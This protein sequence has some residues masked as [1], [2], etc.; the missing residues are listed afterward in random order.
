MGPIGRLNKIILLLL[1]LGAPLA[2]LP[3]NAPWGFERSVLLIA[4]FLALVVWQLAAAVGKANGNRSYRTY[5]TD[6]LL[7]AALPV[8]AFLSAPSPDVRWV[9][10]SSLEL[11][12]A[13]GGILAAVV[14]PAANGR[15]GGARLPALALGALVAVIG[16]IRPI[17]PIGPIKQ[18]LDYQASLGITRST[19]QK[20]PLWGVGP[21]KFGE[22]FLRYKTTD[23][24]SREDWIL[25]YNGSQSGLLELATE[26]GLIGLIGP[27]GLIGL[28]LA[29]LNKKR[30]VG[31][32][33]TFYL[34]SGLL[35]VVVASFVLLPYSPGV[36]WVLGI[37]NGEA[38]KLE[39]KAQN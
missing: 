22:S 8:A 18:G 1:A 15:A 16:L 39:G 26:M 23:F 21:H 7:A 20:E 25:R 6:M 34:L 24:N 36:F 28:I 13:V 14:L 33:L 27:I 19:L 17:G 30:K 9:H 31:G 4:V 38:Q 11:W 3:L 12:A 32:G 5:R 10:L 29:D 35:G 2:M 37:L